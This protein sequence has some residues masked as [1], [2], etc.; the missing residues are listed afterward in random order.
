ML[1]CGFFRFNLAITP[2][3]STGPDDLCLDAQNFS[4]Q[5]GWDFMAEG[6]RRDA[7]EVAKSY[8]TLCALKVAR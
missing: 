2:D 8:W 6:H 3:E 4:E 7:V 1:A 5:V